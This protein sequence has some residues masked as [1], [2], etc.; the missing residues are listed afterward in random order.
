M[1]ADLPDSP[2]GTSGGQK[3]DYRPTEPRR[4]YWSLGTGCLV[5]AVVLV[6]VI[7]VVFGTCMLK[8]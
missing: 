5:V 3:L 2:D 7:G 6:V 4:F 8:R 1:S